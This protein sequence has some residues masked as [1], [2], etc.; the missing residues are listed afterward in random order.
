MRRI[1]LTVIITILLCGFAVPFRV[2]AETEGDGSEAVISGQVDDILSD[3][4]IGY[5]YEDMDELSFGNFFGRIRDAVADRLSAPIK[6]LGL[7]LTV[8]IIV[9]V[10]KGTGESFFAREPSADLYGMI[11]VITAVNVITPQ[12]FSVYGRAVEAIELCG[13]FIAVFVPVFAGLTAAMGGI[14]S[15]GVYDLMILGAS[16]AI[17]QFTKGLF[18]PIV[19][20]AAMLAVSGS[21]FG[22]RSLESVVQLLKKLITW[23]L[24]VSMT[25]FTGF[26]SMKCSLTGK[27]D[28][29]ASKATRFVISGLVPVVGGA[30]S[31]AYSTVRSSFDVIRSTAGT[32]G[33]VGVLLIILPPVLEIIIFRAVMW[34]GTAAAE[35]FSEEHLT[36][37]LK[38]VD[39]GL[40]IAQTVLVCYGLMFIL[41]TA[42]LMRTV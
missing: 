4:D 10:L 31:D 14:T 26:V 35:L 36:K 38:A 15:A 20:A 34:I 37:L 27:T 5:S 39:S 32:A 3:Y 41:C 40:A 17:V 22:N 24:T 11:C 29:I 12:L 18:M 8:I 28:G 33:S 42:I 16:E 19:S 9:S 23:G 1:I 6:M 7:L 25:L 30:V 2:S 21:V 13:G